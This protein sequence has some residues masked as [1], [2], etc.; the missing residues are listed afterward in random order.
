MH[1]PVVKAVVVALN[2]LTA[3]LPCSPVACSG[4]QQPLLVP[5]HAATGILGVVTDTADGLF[6]AATS[7]LACRGGSDLFPL[8]LGEAPRRGRR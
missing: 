2:A 5:V 1:L 4:L 7:P 3:P 6:S 8:C